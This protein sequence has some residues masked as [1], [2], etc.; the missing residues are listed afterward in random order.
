MLVLFAEK[1]VTE[2]KRLERELED[3]VQELQEFYDMAVGRELR[4]IELREEMD[5]LKLELGEY[6]KR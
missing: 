4:M 5:K 6:K 1:D 2:S 3:K